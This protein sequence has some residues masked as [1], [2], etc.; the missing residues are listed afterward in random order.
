MAI[1][2]TALLPLTQTYGLPVPPLVPWIL[3]YN[4]IWSAAQIPSSRHIL[5][6]IT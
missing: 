2:V 6:S 3:L 1:Y 4:K 5:K